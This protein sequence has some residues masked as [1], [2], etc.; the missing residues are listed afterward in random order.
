MT[1]EGIDPSIQDA[2]ARKPDTAWVHRDL[3]LFGWGVAARI[4]P[5]SGADRFD[6]AL[7]RL[8][9]T[10]APMA[11]A[12]FTFDE[13]DPH[14]VIVV[15]K[16]LMKIDKDGTRFV[17]GDQ[18]TVPPPSDDDGLSLGRLVAADVSSWVRLVGEALAAIRDTEV[19]KVV[20]SRRVETTF[21]DPVQ[22]HS[23]LSK[24]VRNEP[25]SHTYLVDRFV[26]SSP[27][28]LV[29]L[30]EGR[31]TSVSLAGSADAGDPGAA[32]SFETDKMMREHDLAAD[33]VDLALGPFCTRLERSERG[34]VSYGDIQHLTTV[35]VGDTIPGTTITD[36]LGALHP[37]AAVA[38]TPTKSALELIRELEGHKRGRYA[39][40]VGWFDRDGEGEFAIALRCGMIEDQKVTLYTGAGIVEGSDPAEEFE[41]TEIKLRPMKGALGIS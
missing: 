41:E 15:P 33:S 8:R 2:L 13:N 27:E 24:L 6:R 9:A 38:G 36:L 34:V 29:S 25:E 4:D 19:E 18:T 37:T 22:A 10:E 35:F 32:G 3:A 28:L 17:I 39:G 40:P 20:L 31:V 16:A 30:G 12:S 26:G 1:A 14:S 7:R 5:G 21:D 23:V 11:L